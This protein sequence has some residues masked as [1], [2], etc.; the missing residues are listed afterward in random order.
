MRKIRFISVFL[1]L[2][3]LAYFFQSC[4]NEL[5]PEPTPTPTNSSP[6]TAPTNP[7]TPPPTNPPSTQDVAFNP[8]K[9]VV[10]VV[11]ISNPTVTTV[12][13]GTE[14]DLT[15]MKFTITYSDGSTDTQTLT[16]TYNK[17]D[18][19]IDPIQYRAKETSHSVYYIKEYNTS[20]AMTFKV[21]DNKEAK[22]ENLIDWTPV[23][24]AP[25]VKKFE[26]LGYEITGVTITGKYASDTTKTLFPTVDDS[27]GV[28]S[29]SLVF[30][31]TTKNGTGVPS[32][33]AKRE[34][35]L[36]SA[37]QE[38]T[39]AEINFSKDLVFNGQIT[40]DDPRFFG[41]KAKEHWY[42]H[43]KDA[44]IGLVYENN[45]ITQKSI[46]LVESAMSS[47]ESIQLG[48]IPTSWETP[49]LEFYYYTKTKPT[50]A[51]ESPGIK[52]KLAV[53]L[54]NT[55]ASIG[56]DYN[57]TTPIVLNGKNSDKELNFLGKAR[58]YAIYQM[59]TNKS[60]TV[61][62][63]LFSTDSTSGTITFNFWYINGSQETAI[64]TNV[65]PAGILTSS[66][67]ASYDK[68]KRLQ[69]ARV[70]YNA[71]A[72]NLKSTDQPSQSKSATLKVGVTGY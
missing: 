6:S 40:F 24:D 55:L 33:N 45:T 43:L 4:E 46:R 68:D 60:N 2:F 16:S 25:T 42:G 12:Y 18:F 3:A 9:Y 34:Y 1:A 32:A 51:P 67:S 59:N 39:L 35:K 14:V 57:G 61:K 63:Y 52:T 56:F 30:G 70:T 47:S 72:G 50:L 62:K 11:K 65:N 71:R 26:G 10:S 13:E 41:D 7:T 53:P 66:N 21:S 28:A 54:Y 38:Y 48:T 37:I 19:S 36:P 64:E 69:N 22:L 15:G 31:D 27:K 29:A 58:P 17:A 49:E 44:V 20:L 23:G 8:G 5:P